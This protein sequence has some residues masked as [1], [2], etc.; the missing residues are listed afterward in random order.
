MDAPLP[1]P[2]LVPP[3][4]SRP[5]P[6][7]PLPFPPTHAGGANRAEH[8]HRRHARGAIVTGV[9]LSR[10]F[11]ASA[12]LRS[13]ASVSFVQH[14]IADVTKTENED[15]TS[16]LMKNPIFW[17]KTSQAV[18]AKALEIV[19]WRTVRTCTHPRTTTTRWRGN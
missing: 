2:P 13:G 9:A 5:L 6:A 1:A 8:T 7:C 17:E 19:L 3:V 16:K 10:K 15:S 18:G 4:P 12:A 14:M 11:S